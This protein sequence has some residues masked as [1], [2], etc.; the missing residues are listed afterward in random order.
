MQIS[1]YMNQRGAIYQDFISKD[2]IDIDGNKVYE[3]PFIAVNTN[4]LKDY[5]IKEKEGTVLNLTDLKK[6]CYWFP[7]S[8]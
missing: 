5:Q 6:K 8:I 4:Y 2:R 1:E 7:K 3:Q